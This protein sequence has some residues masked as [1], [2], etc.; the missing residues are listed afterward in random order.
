MRIKLLSLLLL[1]TL[2]LSAQHQ[3]VLKTNEDVAGYYKIP[4]EEVFI[5][6]N[7][8]LLFA[9]EYL[10]YKLYCINADSRLLSDISKIAYVSLIDEKGQRIFEHKIALENGVGQGD[11]FVPVTIPSGNY[12]LVGYTQWMLNVEGTYFFHGDVSI[13]NPYQS[14]QKE[15]VSGESH[16]DSLIQISNNSKNPVAFVYDKQETKESDKIILDATTYKKRSP[17]R[18]TL[19]NMKLEEG[20]YSIS[21]R[22]KD[23]FKKATVPT[24][25]TYSAI[26]NK[27]GNKRIKSKGSLIYLPEMRG[28]LIY[29]KIISKDSSIP[30]AEVRIGSSIDGNTSDVQIVST[31]AKGDFII[32]LHKRYHDKK[33]RIEVLGEQKENYTILLEDIP[34]INS[35]KMKF[36]SFEINTALKDEILER[37]IFN[38]ID[39]SF[40][41]L[42]PDTIQ[43]PKTM[44]SFYGNDY[45]NYDLDDYTRFATVKETIIEIVEGVGTR[46]TK[47]K[48]EV[49]TIQ[50][51]Y[52]IKNNNNFLPL[53]LVDGIIVQDHNSVINFDARKIKNIGFIRN[54]YYLGTKIF[55]GILILNSINKGFVTNL[56]DPYGTSYELPR[57]RSTK[58][59][60]KQVYKDENKYNHI[61]DY[62][63]Q[64]LWEPEVVLKN[65]VDQIYEF[66]TSDVAG[67]YE[68]SIQGF[69]NTGSSISIGKTFKVE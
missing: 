6:Y 26:F 45:E 15:I 53:V 25:K 27:K 54:K 49:F 5:H 59:Y 16:I 10:Y 11:F 37:S 9:G 47:K 44:S 30:I 46:K 4:Q 2:S 57:P 55:D 41:N 48:D 38:Q 1:F 50:G 7:T 3:S 69:T 64:L 28:E 61:P 58:K 14:D 19:N 13:I 31:N 65:E 68:I 24:T 23:K 66:F 39:N 33:V 63:N 32:N 20:N 22:K 43:T 42:K 18:L 67:D 29:G 12:K 34:K 21:I 62:R 51:N 35:S 36:Y 56:K 52:S 17:V 60:F 40:Y 8:S